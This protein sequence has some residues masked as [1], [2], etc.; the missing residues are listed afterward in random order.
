M[1]KETVAHAGDKESACAPNKI[2]PKIISLKEFKQ[3]L[4]DL[5][6][7]NGSFVDSMRYCFFNIPSR[8]VTNHKAIR[9]KKQLLDLFNHH[10]AKYHPEG[11]NFSYHGINH[12]YNHKK[13]GLYLTQDA[14]EALLERNTRKHSNKAF[15]K[16]IKE[17]SQQA[18]DLCE[19]H[20]QSKMRHHL[21]PAR[22]LYS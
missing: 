2:R 11:S 18:F 17:L 16:R 8:W 12:I 6:I 14:F 10:Q 19:D 1:S 22:L 15:V 13:C 20:S 7:E 21:W 4:D 5:V 3:H 9:D